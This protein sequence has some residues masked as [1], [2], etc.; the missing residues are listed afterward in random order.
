ML[1]RV[2]HT[3][4]VGSYVVADT[5]ARGHLQGTEKAH[6]LISAG[7]G[8][9]AGGVA[10]WVLN[11]GI[12]LGGSCLGLVISLCARTTLAHMSVRWHT[13]LRWRRALCHTPSRMCIPTVDLVVV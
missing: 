11:V 10:L 2:D 9:F 5:D 3:L 4:D 7:L 12:F 13:V 8:V 6:L 1:L